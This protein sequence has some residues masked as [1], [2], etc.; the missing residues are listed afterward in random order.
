MWPPGPEVLYC[1]DVTCRHCNMLLLMAQ[2]QSV[3]T[4]REYPPIHVLYFLSLTYLLP[5]SFPPSFLLS[6]L[7]LFNNVTA[8]TCPLSALP[9]VP[10]TLRLWWCEVC[11]SSLL[12]LSLSLSPGCNLCRWQQVD[13]WAAA[14]VCVCVCVCAWGLLT[15]IF[16]LSLPCHCEKPGGDRPRVF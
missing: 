11:L 7:E 6:F 8:V 4:S 12:S 3:T 15:H 14:Y 16:S 9:A 1:G 10:A 13:D 5:L 2:Q